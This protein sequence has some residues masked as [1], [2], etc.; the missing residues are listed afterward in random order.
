MKGI[1]LAAGMG[2]RLYPLTANQPKCMVS[3]NGTPLID[4][5]L[6]NLNQCGISSPIVI[7]GYQAEKLKDHLK[8]NEV[9]HCTNQQFDSTNMVR[10]LF[11]AEKYFDDDLLISYSDIHYT[12]AIVRRLME[13][14]EEVSVIVDRDW[15]KLWSIRFENPLDDA[16]TMKIDEKGF[17]QSLGKK[18]DS[19]KDIEGQYIGLI[20]FSKS[21]LPKIQKLYHSLGRQ[22]EN[23]FMTDFIQEMIDNGISVKAVDIK[24]G[25]VEVDTLSDLERYSKE[26]NA[27]F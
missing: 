15:L 14:Q 5:I 7:S 20:K 21:I 4:S 8:S 24:G 1:V 19:L 12:P 25:W 9:I 23:L 10:S 11:C 2:K 3:Y 26:M 27:I 18:T 16:E 13:S 22:T 17:I 6:D